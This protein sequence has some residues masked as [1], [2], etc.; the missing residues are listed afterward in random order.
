MSL[1]IY[2][3]RHPR[4]DPRQKPPLGARLDP[5]HPLSRG[6]VCRWLLNEGVGNRAGSVGPN[7][8]SGGITKPLWRSGGLGFDGVSTHCVAQ[9]AG[10]VLVGDHTVHMRLRFEE[11]EGDSRNRCLLAN[12]YDNLHGT[13]IFTYGPSN[14]AI[15]WDTPSGIDQC[16]WNT[17]YIP[18]NKQV[19]ATTF[20]CKMDTGRSL[21]VNGQFYAG[22][23]SIPANP[24]PGLPDA[25]IGF[26]PN[27]SY[28]GYYFSGTMWD[29]AIW[30][31]ALS[32]DEIAWLYA[33]PYAGL[34]PPTSRRIYSYS[35]RPRVPRVHHVRRPRL[36]PRQKP[37]LGA[38]LDPEHSLSR[39]L[40]RYWVC[41]EG[42]GDR[43]GDVAANDDGVRHPLYWAEG[44]LQFPGGSYYIVGNPLNALS[45]PCTYLCWFS[46]PPSAIPSAGGKIR[47]LISNYTDTRS[48]GATG[49]SLSV[50]LRSN[51]NHMIDAYFGTGVPG[52][53]YIR[54]T[55][56]PSNIGRP[57][58]ANT[59]GCAAITYDGTQGRLYFDGQQILNG[60]ASVAYA[61]KP[62]TL[63]RWA[64]NNPGYVFN[65]LLRNIRIYNRALTD[66]EIAWLYAEPYAGLLPPT[67]RRIYSYSRRGIIRARAIDGTP[68][69]GVT[70]R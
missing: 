6:L 12:R 29:V 47:G 19:V 16:R 31:R 11:A 23:S 63:G 7:K 40:V 44:A 60:A 57:M 66:D 28:D 37:P 18:P 26:D 62:W 68:F 35:H 61:A 45:G 65:G 39:G 10:G 36:D 49:I 56:T 25:F 67:S 41:N 38:R 50:T 3:R 14:R 48:V 53:Q 33:E 55:G 24:E 2:H 43:I 4:L 20:R 54:L 1:R 15:T 21:Y 13:I 8:I 22:T 30:R 34:L 32:D 52:A 69:G 5:E 42:I 70:I 64:T 51:Y 27:P 17:R 58:T 9:G 59:Y 46:F